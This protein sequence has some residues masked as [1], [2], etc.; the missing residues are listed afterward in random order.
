MSGSVTVPGTGGSTVTIPFP[1]SYSDFLAQQIA[2]A[3]AAAQGASNLEV[4]TAGS[5]DATPA[6]TAGAVNQLIITG[7]GGANNV[8]GYQFVVNNNT[9]PD[10]IGG[11]DV[12]ILS[13]SAGGSFWVS[14]NSTVAAVGGNNVIVGEP[15]G[16]YQLAGG[17]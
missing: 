7:G 14:G 10:S 16:T 5:G 1:Q 11:S 13:G 4:T 2:N 8:T 9:S 3:L 6:T 15:G 17:D 12:G